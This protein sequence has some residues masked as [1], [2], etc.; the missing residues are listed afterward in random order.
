MAG[1][2]QNDNHIHEDAAGR[3]VSMAIGLERS[4]EG[5]DD[6]D[7]LYLGLLY[8]FEHNGMSLQGIKGRVK[9]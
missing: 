4:L 6:A 8:E 7:R 1:K 2:R 3:D 9:R 5:L